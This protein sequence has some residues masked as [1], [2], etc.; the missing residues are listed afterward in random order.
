MHG[1]FL[2]R[3]PEEFRPPVPRSCSLGSAFGTGASAAL[4]F[5]KPTRPTSGGPC[6]R[7][8]RCAR[9]LARSSQESELRSERRRLDGVLCAHRRNRRG[10]RGIRRA[11]R[12]S[13]SARHRFA[14]SPGAR[15]TAQQLRRPRP[16]HF[17]HSSHSRA[18]GVWIQAKRASEQIAE[19]PR[20][21]APWPKVA[22]KPTLVAPLHFLGCRVT[23]RWWRARGLLSSRGSGSATGASGVEP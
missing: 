8:M 4:A 20:A 6:L 5:S 9:G 15:R 17:S 21:N 11:A 12:G 22:N 18:G 1:L 14:P 3:N 13:A 7:A 2:D 19:T 23:I 16:S 10:A